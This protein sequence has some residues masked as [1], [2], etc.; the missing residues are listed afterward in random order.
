[1]NECMLLCIVCLYTC[2]HA[3]MRLCMYVYMYACVH[4]CMYV[5]SF[6]VGFWAVRE[7]ELSFLG[8]ELSGVNCPEGI[9]WGGN[10]RSPVIMT[11]MVWF[12]K[13][14]NPSQWFLKLRSES[15]H[16][17]SEKTGQ[18]LINQAIIQSGYEAEV[19]WAVVG[20]LLNDTRYLTACTK[21]MGSGF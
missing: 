21:L 19:D 11:S 6:Q 12:K 7:G 2:V 4:T 15:R 10:V 8:G 20:S 13:T 5:C 1:M 18:N 17:T 14:W 9:V 16:H 3:S